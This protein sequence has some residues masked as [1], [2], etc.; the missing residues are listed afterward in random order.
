MGGLS[1]MIFGVY[2]SFLLMGICYFWFLLFFW[3]SVIFGFYCF[4]LI[5]F[6]R[7]DK[8]FGF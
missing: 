1:S 6:Y 8:C 7:F 3:V 2:P 5:F 4:F